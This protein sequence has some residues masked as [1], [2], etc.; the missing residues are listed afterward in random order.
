ML[1][2][3]EPKAIMDELFKRGDQPHKKR[4]SVVFAHRTF[5]DQ[6]LA[7]MDGMVKLSVP[8][9][10]IMAL[11]DGA[12]YGVVAEEKQAECVGGCGEMRLLSRAP[13][14]EL[15]ADQKPTKETI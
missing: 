7:S 2:T 15:E 10:A 4:S 9:L 1:Y 11:L 5:A 8:G 3:I 6:E 13:L 12:V 14:V